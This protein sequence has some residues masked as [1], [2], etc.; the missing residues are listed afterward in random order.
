M[1]NKYITAFVLTEDS[2]IARKNFEQLNAYNV[3]QDSYL[4]ISESAT[5]SS[6][7][8]KII[9]TKS[10]GS[11][12]LFKE[13][14]EKCESKYILLLNRNSRIDVSEDSLIKYLNAAEVKNAGI[15]YSDFYEKSGREI[16]PHPLIDY[17]YG[18]IR[19]DFEFGPLML[20]RKEALDNF[21]E[22]NDDYWF[23]GLYS[24]RLALSRNHSLIRIPQPLYTTDKS[25]NRKSGERQ[26][27]YVDPQNHEVQIEMEDTATHHLKNIEAYIFATEKTVDFNSEEFEYE[28]SIII[29]VKN[30][31]KTIEDALHSALNQK[32]GFKYN[33]IVIDNHSKDGTTETLSS[34][35]GKD[36]RIIHVIPERED[37]E[38]GGC[39]N[40]AVEH[41]LCGKFAVQLD[42]DDLYLNDDT[43]N[44]II[45]K[46]CEEKCAMV[47][48][49]YKLTDFNM[50]EIPPG[51]I[52][53]KEWTNDNGHNN[54]LRINGLG[55]P[56][57]FYVPIIRKIKFPNVSYGE[58]YAVALAI[59]REYKI[60]RIYE[61]LYLCRRWEGNTDADLSIGKQNAH[62]YYKDSIRTKE[63][64]AR[65]KLNQIKIRTENN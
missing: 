19:D 5:S 49:S 2:D 42:S 63:I 39:W 59:S 64:Y 11:S 34:F 23:A 44:K 15:V 12:K 56:R 6:P 21:Y 28:V 1:L 29:P 3:V 62:N 51:I 30:R 48:G 37:L 65:Q 10:A 20:I 53:H 22:Q 4:A 13:I 7:I 52:D 41:A 9:K 40:V 57:A 47:I 43:L 60:G 54:A 8:H 17:Q 33:V 58:D 24:L 50:N 14:Y 16:I 46:F 45:N 61:S 55:A 32:T 18:S 26:F 25:D 38:I 31:V 27:D 35:A 36:K